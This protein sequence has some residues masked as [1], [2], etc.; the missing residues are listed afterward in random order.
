[1]CGRV[2]E[3]NLFKLLNLLPLPHQ[4]RSSVPAATRTRQDRR[5]GI[6]H[7]FPGIS[8]INQPSNS[9][10]NS[11]QCARVEDS[12][13]RL[14]PRTICAF[15][16]RYKSRNLSS[17]GSRDEEAPLESS[18]TRMRKMGD[19]MGWMSIEMRFQYCLLTYDIWTRDLFLARINRIQEVMW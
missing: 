8:T 2:A 10:V 9:N 1:M 17:R 7:I 14:V 19:K 13:S 18:R 4:T 3:S 15:V 12:A 5:G 6:I 11:T 16:I